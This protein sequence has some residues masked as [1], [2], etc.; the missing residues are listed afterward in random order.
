MIIMCNTC[1]LLS[2]FNYITKICWGFITS[3]V[4]PYTK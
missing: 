2:Y 1:C 4:D 3:C